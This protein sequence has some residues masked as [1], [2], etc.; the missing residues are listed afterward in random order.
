[1]KHKIDPTVDCV[2]KKILGAEKNKNLLIHFL[3]SVLE[4]EKGV[5]IQDVTIVNPYN[6]REF[7]GD[8]LTIVD[9]KAVD[10][11]KKHYQIEIQLAFHAGLKSRIMFT[12]SS[13]YH[14]QL[15]KGDDYIKLKPV[16]SIWIINENIFD[17]V[18]ACH[19][20]FSVYNSE[21]KLK[22]TDDLAIHILQLPKWE[23]AGKI[24]KEKE[25]WIYF[26]KEGK[27]IDLDNPPDILETKE[28]RQAMRILQNFSE[29]QR[30]YLLYQSR[31]DAILKENTI[32]NEVKQITIEMEKAK[33][34][35]E[36]NKRIAEQNKKMAEQSEKKAAQSKKMAEQN[37]KMAE[38]SEKIAEQ[39]EKQN[40]YLLKL[41]KEK[42]ISLPD[43]YK[44]D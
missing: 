1:M 27:H 5:L 28:M 30:D 12:W 31:L 16:I 17:D 40:Q 4:L 10:E 20:P 2:F 34:I 15:N 26:F 37:K 36:Q 39:R 3:N 7:I 18:E 21:H 24:N 41:L 43:E 13:M 22:L 14:S 8:K 25:R 11:N 35:A 23:Y 9:I 19:I 38:Q 32:R 6:E 42:G 29:R 44:V 33:K